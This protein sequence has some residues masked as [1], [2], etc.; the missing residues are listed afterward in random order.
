[1]LHG[2]CTDLF[3]IGAGTAYPSAAPEFTPVFSWVRVTW[4]LVVCACFVDRCLS[5]C[6]FSFGHCVVCSSS[7]YRFWS[8]IWYLQAHLRTC[9]FLFAPHIACLSLLCWLIFHIFNF[10]YRK[11]SLQI[12]NEGSESVYWRRTDN[13]MTK[14]KRAKGQTTIYKTYT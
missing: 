13:T 2:W 8:L 1:M 9:D 5:F 7:I 11:M 10:L 14:R 12:P 4:S 3:N 6:S